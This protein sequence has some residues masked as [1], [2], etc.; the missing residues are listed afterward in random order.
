MTPRTFFRPLAAALAAT[1]L[2][3]GCSPDR[4][5]APSSD[6]PIPAAAVNSIYTVTN[7]QPGTTVPVVERSESL[8]TDVSV[9]E[10]IG[11]RGG[12]LRIGKA[13][14]LVYFSP[15]AVS[16]PTVITATA[17]A[18]SLVSYNFEPH[19]IQFAAPV[20]V[21]QNLGQTTLG[22]QMNAAKTIAGAYTPDG[23]ADISVA[24][25]TARVSEIHDAYVST[26]HAS[27]GHVVLDQAIFTIQ[28]FS[29]YILTGGR[30]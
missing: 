17:N 6:S 23:V 1:M 14:L 9:T 16:A 25:A 22:E 28:H 27:G 2:G 26:T 19:G 12:F 11:P 30:R 8:E 15:G 10:T 4:A 18:G 24:T 3:T 7:A 29:G 13:G 21:V 5:V 20:Y